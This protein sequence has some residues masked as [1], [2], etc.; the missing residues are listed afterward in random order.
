MSGV[1]DYGP[2]DHPPA[3]HDSGEPAHD[4]PFDFA[5]ETAPLDTEH[6]PQG[7]TDDETIY[8]PDD[9][10]APVDADHHHHPA[11][12]GSP[13]TVPGP[14]WAQPVDPFDEP[15]AHDDS[16][17]TALDTD[18]VATWAAEP[19][20]HLP[21]VW[22]DATSARL[23]ELTPHPAAGVAAVLLGGSEPGSIAAELWRE[24]LPSEPLPV[25]QGGQV[26]GPSELLD[27]LI[28]RLDDPAQADVGPR[29]PRGPGA[30]SSEPTARAA[31]LATRA[32][33]EVG[34]ETAEQL[35][36]VRAGLEEPL[37]VAIAG[38][39][40]S[41]KSTLVNALLQQTVAPT[42]AGECTQFVT[43]FRY[44]APPAHSRAEII[45]RDGSTR[46]LALH[47]GRLPSGRLEVAADNVEMLRVWL[48]NPALQDLTLIDTPGLNSAH[49]DTAA[50]T[51]ELLRIDRDSRRALRGAD[52]VLFV[53][54]AELNAEEIALLREYVA[55]SGGSA[56]TV[57]GVLSKADLVGNVADPWRRACQL[58]ERHSGRLQRE[59]AAVLPA[60]GLLAQT[61]ET[62]ALN[63]QHAA[64]L[65]TIA[66]AGIDVEHR[67]LW[68]PDHFCHDEQ[69]PIAV[70][71][72]RSLLDILGIYGLKLTIALTRDGVR[73][74]ADLQRA[75]AVRSGLDEVRRSLAQTFIPRAG[76]L[77]TSS[78]LG[79]M[80]DLSF[81]GPPEDATALRALRDGIEALKYDESMHQVA[82]FD[83]L[84]DCLTLD[85]A[86]PDDMTRARHR[87][88]LTTDLYEDVL[89]LV[90]N[91]AARQ[92][93]GLDSGVTDAELM[94][95]AQAGASKWI[96]FGNKH[97]GSKEKKIARI[98]QRSYTL[99]FLEAQRAA[100]QS[101]HP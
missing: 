86:D 87:V 64:D 83:A 38:H 8:E 44:A 58:A 55:A 77:K 37:R 95:A 73:G 32:Q 52:M 42:D 10:G 96:A 51:E 50:R 2:H 72:R 35:A 39:V 16:F 3:D 19:A 34:P 62:Y 56:L 5:P 33:G 66:D 15:T 78:A 25:D 30:V 92:R 71:R 12:S 26:L 54:N 18:Y 57:L 70:E 81:G 9:F 41:G 94:R 20:D 76:V 43:E 48:R 11:V 79:R 100:A 93:C 24:S 1:D 69:I 89:R 85:I 47:H 82:E 21:P 40:S 65:A 31:E 6:Y 14:S 97:I 49:E 101:A 60:L 28:A 74:A 36:L 90:R 98:I 46:P 75:L 27:Q 63:E 68:G 84:R 91:T 23:A 80:K 99:M 13:E 88:A 61:A 7:H 22:D 45:L 4:E 53:I 67:A 29:R 59:V 17:V